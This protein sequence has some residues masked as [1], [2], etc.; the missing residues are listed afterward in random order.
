MDSSAVST[1]E[2][3]NSG[4]AALVP[5]ISCSEESEGPPSAKKRKPLQ[6]VSRA[7]NQDISPEKLRAERELLNVRAEA[8]RQLRK[9]LQTAHPEAFPQTVSSTPPTTP[10]SPVEAPTV[11]SP[12]ATFADAALS[13]ELRNR[14]AAAVEPSMALPGVSFAQEGLGLGEVMEALQR[15]SEEVKRARGRIAHQ[16]R[17][18]SGASGGAA[19]AMA[20]AEGKENQRLAQKP[21]NELLKPSP[22]TIPCSSVDGNLQLRLLRKAR[23][24]VLAD[25]G[26]G[27]PETLA[28]LKELCAGHALELL[29]LNE[30]YFTRAGYTGTLQGIKARMDCLQMAPPMKPIV[31]VPSSVLPPEGPVERLVGFREEVLAEIAGPALANV[32]RLRALG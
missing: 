18:L 23:G 26:V 8:L 27:R 7:P 11:T 30:T 2:P 4:G 22:G 12:P 15:A 29:S 1:A 28:K 3:G 20:A 10:T 6:A 17:R 9:L 32:E 13:E 16:Q 14:C 19:P 25:N 31:E 24:L 21:I 5:P